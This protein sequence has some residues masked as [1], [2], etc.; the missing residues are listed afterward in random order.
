MGYLTL[1]SRVA[2]L[3][4]SLLALSAC[5]NFDRPKSVTQ[6][7]G[8]VILCP[9]DPR[10]GRLDAAADATTT[11]LLTQTRLTFQCGPRALPCPGAGCPTN[12]PGLPGQA[13]KV[14]RTFMY[15]QCPTP[16]A[17]AA[18]PAAMPPAE[19]E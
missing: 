18:E 1:S 6:D 15:T 12:K 2:V 17:P 14:N 3:S 7:S 13:C 10:C 9:D 8:D 4:L 19:T 5:D 16:R 11:C